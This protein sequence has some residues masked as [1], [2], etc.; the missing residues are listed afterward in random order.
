[1]SKNIIAQI[2]LE[3]VQCLA[4]GVILTS[5]LP[6]WFGLI[7]TWQWLAITGGAMLAGLALEVVKHEI[8]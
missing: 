8:I 4:F 6:L 3:A 1:M 5:L 2:L 7:N